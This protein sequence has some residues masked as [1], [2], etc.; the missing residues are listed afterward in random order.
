MVHEIR[1]VVARPC[2]SFR[3]TRVRAACIG[4]SVAEQSHAV[5]RAFS[6]LTGALDLMRSTAWRVIGLFNHDV[7]IGKIKFSTGALY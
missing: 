7:C 5:Y 3:A 1:R 2:F 4:L 6:Q